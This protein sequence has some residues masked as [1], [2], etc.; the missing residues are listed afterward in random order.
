[1]AR[2]DG[3]RALPLWLFVLAA[4]L[5]AIRIALTFLAPAPRDEQNGEGDLVRWV[6]LEQAA[7][8]SKPVLYDFT[9][10]WCGPCRQMEA[11]VYA[12]PEFAAQINERFTPVKVVDRKREDGA[13]REAVEA[14]QQRF[15]VRAFPTVVIVDGSGAAAA[16]MEGFRGPAAFAHLLDSVR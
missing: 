16:K 13:N 5:L 8:S 2:T 9:A 1:M 6:P 14:L 10:A 15:A 4:A 3:Q 7:A 11:E 12:D